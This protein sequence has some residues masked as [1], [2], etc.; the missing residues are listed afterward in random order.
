MTNTAQTQSHIIDG[1]MLAEKIKGELKVEVDA[2]IAKGMRPPGLAVMLIGDD[3][4]SHLYVKNK[5]NS[6]KKVGIHSVLAQLDKDASMDEVK[7]CLRKLN[8][9][10]AIDGILVQLPLPKH[11]NEEELL[12]IMDPSKDADGLHPYN[13]GSLVQGKPGLRPCTPL[14]IIS[15]LQHYKVEI[16]GANAVVI[17]RSKLVGKPIALLLMEQNAT[18]KVCHSRTKDLA[19]EV[20]K[21]DILV[22]AMG[23]G[24]F[25]KA[26]WIKKGAVVIDVGIHHEKKAD[27]MSLIYGDVDYEPASKVA[28]LITPVPGGVGPMTVT[29]LLCN[30]IFAYKKRMGLN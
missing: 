17:G 9:D 14:G 21:A 7:A 11:L 5:I 28:S 25:V 1:K 10:E 24:K 6:C 30:T 16:A 29:Q 20:R 3:P 19:D 26:D 27:G 2:F 22:V 4:A 8:E 23:K 15:L 13:L 18:V 12:D